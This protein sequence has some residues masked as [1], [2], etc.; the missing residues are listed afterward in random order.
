[1]K[2]LNSLKKKKNASSEAVYMMGTPLQRFIREWGGFIGR[3]GS[4]ACL[5]II[6]FGIIFRFG[7]CFGSSM[8]PTLSNGEIVLFQRMN[9]SVD[10]GDII[11]VQKD[12]LDHA[13]IKR[14]I[15]K[16]GDTIEI[17]AAHG[18]VYRNGVALDE[19][20]IA[21][22]TKT[23]GHM[24]GP[25]TVEEGCYFVMGDNRMNSLDSRYSSVGTVSRDEIQEKLL[26]VLFNPFDWGTTE[27]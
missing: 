22:P 11:T 26:T 9:I 23:R 6:F 8:E 18:V 20:Y 25:V 7:V 3:L 5:Y 17:D 16:A 15:G 13:L 2:F 10:Y 27:V 14:V 12:G 24:S 19:P 1:M 21:E 4:F